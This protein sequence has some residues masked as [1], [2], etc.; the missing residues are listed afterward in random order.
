M[1]RRITVAMV[2][3]VVA[4]LLFSGVVTLVLAGDQARIQTRRELVREAQSLAVSVR[5]EAT[6]TNRFAPAR[7]LRTILRALKAPLRLQDEA[8]LA[9]TS[10]GRLIDPATPVQH[11]TLPRGITR[12]ELDIAALQAG[13]SVSGSHGSVVYAAV[14]DRTEVQIGSVPR[15]VLLVVILTRQGPTGLG[16]SSPWFF[17]ACAVI[18]IV[19]L[20]VANRLGHRFVRPLEAAQRVTGQIA[21]GDLS[22]RVP[23]PPGTDPEMAAL[24]ASI[25]AMAASLARAR[26]A[27]RQFLLSVSHDLRTPLTSIRGFA[28]AIEDGATEDTYRA[29]GVIATEAR[30]LERLVGDLLALAQLESRRFTLRLEPTDLAGVAEATASAFVPAAEELGLTL[31]NRA[32]P[33]GLVHADP[34][35]LAQVVANLVENASKYARSQVWVGTAISEGQPVLWVDDDGPGI[36]REDLQRVFDRLYASH[37][38]RGRQVGSGLGLAIVA[39]LVSAMG[40]SVRAESPIHGQGGGT[41]VVVTLRPAEAP[42]SSG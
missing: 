22:A 7:S 28:E 30:R 25:N 6:A 21:A 11:P 42:T 20:V 5:Q 4:T 2:L 37:P 41:R 1:R 24:T 10:A 31:V 19:A 26:G 12:A 40:G 3:M 14:P 9:I 27:E 15:Q 17:L 13:Q 36:A 8:V 39:E 35:R 33:A 29:A 23:E 16:T 34:D 38:R 18:L 32:G